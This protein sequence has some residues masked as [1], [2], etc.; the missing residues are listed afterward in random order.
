MQRW[1]RSTGHKQKEMGANMKNDDKTTTEKDVEK[2]NEPLKGKEKRL[3]QRR[4]IE[5]LFE[6]KRTKMYVDDYDY[7]FG[8]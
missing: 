7:Y 4:H 2:K 3:T 6:E 5:D 8:E 1:F